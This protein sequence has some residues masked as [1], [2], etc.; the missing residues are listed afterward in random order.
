MSVKMYDAYRFPRGKLDEFILKFNKVCLDEV[1]DLVAEI[2]LSEK[3][4][5]ETR[6][7]LFGQNRKVSA[8]Y[9]DGEIELIWVMAQAM[10]MSKTGQNFPFHLDCSFNL[11]LRGRY[12]YVQPFV[13]NRLHNLLQKRLPKWCEFYGYWDNTDQPEGVSRASWEARK[14]IWAELALDDWDR[15]RLTHIVLEM[16]MPHLNGFKTLLKSINPDEEWCDKIYMAATSLFY[17]MEEKRE[18]ERLNRRSLKVG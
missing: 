14:S 1:R 4:I 6:K 16:K 3:T 9:K 10:M 18:A 8:S 7:Q 11:W 13:V 12:A 15:T 2:S 5:G 17:Q